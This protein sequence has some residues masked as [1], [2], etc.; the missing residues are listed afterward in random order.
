MSVL[1]FIEQERLYR[2]FHLDEPW[3]SAHNRKLIDKMPDLFRTSPA[4]K[5]GETTLLGIAGESGMFPGCKALTFRDVTDGTSNTIWFVDADDAHAVPWTRP[6]DFRHDP[7]N[8]IVGLVGHF[9]GRF[10]AAF[11]DG[12]ARVIA[13][14]A[15]AALLNAL[16]TRNW[17]E[18]VGRIP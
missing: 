6:E 1:P 10:V 15:D 12:S 17:G 5:P 4:L 13:G 18:I 7:K 3:D 2:Q 8:P 11:V 14:K 16:F 9:R